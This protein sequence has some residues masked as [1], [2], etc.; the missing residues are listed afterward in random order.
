MKKRVYIKTT[1]VSYL[2]AK[3]SPLLHTV[4]RQEITRD[5]WERRRALY[6]LCLSQIVLDEAGDGDP[7][8]ARRRLAVVKDMAVLAV[9]QEARAL[10]RSLV[11]EGLLP[12]AASTD[13][14][15]LALATIHRVEVLLTWNCRHLANA[16]IL[17]D[18]GDAVRD[19][20][21]RMP[22][23]C[24]PEELMGNEGSDNG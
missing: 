11:A 4:A 23:V 12:E 20:G 16:E 21:Y 5:W 10:A 8:P 19:R 3:P 13:A 2:T 24:T 14:L 18:I 15:H 9:T 17:G 7:V 6:D 1:I 22:M